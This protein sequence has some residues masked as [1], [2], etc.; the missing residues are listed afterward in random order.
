MLHSEYQQLKPAFDDLIEAYHKGEK[1]L[2]YSSFKSFIEGGPRAFFKNRMMREQ[3]DAMI[4]GIAFH[5]CVLEPE[6]YEELYYIFDDSEKVEEL[7]AK[8]AKSPR[9]MKEY[10]DWKVEYVKQFEGKTELKK[11]DDLLYRSF[12]EYLYE[13]ELTKKY[14]DTIIEKEKLYHFDFE[15]FKWTCRVDGVGHHITT[16][17]KKCTNATPKKMKWAIRDMFYDLQGVVCSIATGRGEHAIV[18]IDKAHNTSVFILTGDNMEAVK[19]RLI[20]YVSMFERCIEEDA[21]NQG[22]NYFVNEPEY[23][24][25]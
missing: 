24:I 1:R 14:M 12:R 9:S 5:L 6:K 11:E 17:I 23:V 13:N 7:I 4:Q 22:L 8:G 15:G 3:T 16:D 21:W 10:K 2:S 18:S 25:T 19:D 20:Y